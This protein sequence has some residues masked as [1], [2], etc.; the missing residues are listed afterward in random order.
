MTR[1]LDL[2]LAT[3]AEPKSRSDESER[4]RVS[5]AVLLRAEKQNREFYDENFC[6][7]T[8]WHPKPFFLLLTVR[9]SCR[10]YWEIMQRVEFKN[11]F[12]PR[13]L[14]NVNRGSINFS[15]KTRAHPLRFPLRNHF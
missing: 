11:P 9:N 8:C 13:M 10:C 2:R 6:H 1:F 15:N 14:P 12:S 5:L 3:F 7:S 4:G